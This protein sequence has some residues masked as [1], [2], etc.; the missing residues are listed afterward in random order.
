MSIWKKRITVWCWNNYNKR[1]FKT[2]SY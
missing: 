1:I 2:L